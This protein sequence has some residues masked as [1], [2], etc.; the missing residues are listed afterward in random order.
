MFTACLDAGVPLPWLRAVAAKAPPEHGLWLGVHRDA[1]AVPR[2]KALV[3]FLVDA[4][5]PLR[6][7]LRPPPVR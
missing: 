2:V 1:R 7:A 6:R 4:L 5:A 3:A